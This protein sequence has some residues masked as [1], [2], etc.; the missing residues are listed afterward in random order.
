MWIK[1]TQ[2]KIIGNAVF[3]KHKYLT[4]STITNADVLLNAANGLQTTLKDGILQAPQT[5]AA[6]RQLIQIFKA[7]EEAA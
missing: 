2:S 5:T 1:E 7:N 6:V 4:M 3:F